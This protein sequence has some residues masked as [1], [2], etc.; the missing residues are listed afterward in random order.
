M[1]QKDYLEEFE[2]MCAVMLEVTRAKN[3][4][5]A[6]GNN[7]AFTNFEQIAH[8]TNGK[9]S[10]EMGIL[11]RMTDKMSRITNLLS[12]EA[13]VKE[14]SLDDTLKDLAVYATILRIYRRHKLNEES[15]KDRPKND[16]DLHELKGVYK[17]NDR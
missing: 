2:K 7:N 10:V 8:L 11:V 15:T 17:G 4:D 9:I 3:I 12:N 14:E 6:G 1:T 16:P 5:Y 13:Q